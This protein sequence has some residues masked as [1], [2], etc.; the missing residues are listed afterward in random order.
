MT[1]DSPIRL[2]D[3]RDF[4]SIIPYALG[5]HPT[6]S[7]VVACVR[8]NGGLGMIARSSFADLTP[9][10]SGKEIAALVAKNVNDDDA[11]LVFLVCY[12]QKTDEF[13]KHRMKK[14]LGL[15]RKALGDI[16]VETW[17]VGSHRFYSLD[18]TSSDCCPKNGF[19]ISELEAS[20]PSVALVYEGYAPAA[21]R[22]VYTCLPEATPEARAETEKALETT[23]RE[24][25]GLDSPKAFRQSAFA[26]WLRLLEYQNR[27]EVLGPDK[28]GTLAAALEDRILRD[29][30]LASCLPHGNDIA[31]DLI[32]EK[33]TAKTGV[34]ELLR[35]IVQPG[36]GAPEPKK[37]R[38]VTAVL[39]ALSA[40][41]GNTARVAPLTLRAF[42]AWWAGDGTL[43]N[44]RLEAV[45]AIDSAYQLAVLLSTAM[46]AGIRP[47][48]IRDDTQNSRVA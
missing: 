42:L 27:G 38:Q 21:T 24:M 20:S 7:V 12:C 14:Y 16:P 9:V 23:R 26:I 37:Y 17:V 4:L 13:T 36:P 33:A 43:A 39:D 40:H 10:R 22:S 28:L 30:V 15:F 19:D 46:Q 18:C 34:H 41:V 3:P 25:N 35:A 6:D 47:G 48:W 29:A 44:H 45:S 2:T 5:Y 11:A 31:L 1:T 8:A 32:T